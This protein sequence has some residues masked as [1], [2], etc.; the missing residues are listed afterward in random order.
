LT[1]S[2]VPDQTLLTAAGQRL[3]ARPRLRFL[4]GGAGSGK[5]AVARELAARSDVTVVDM[6]ARIY[7]T[8]ADCWQRGRHPVASAWL[9]S[10]DPLAMQLAMAPEAFLEFQ[11]ALAVE[12]LDLLADEL[13][14]E[15][16]AAGW[17]VVDGGFGSIGVLTEAVP[18]AWVACLAAADLDSTALW[19][20]DPDRRAFLDMVASVEA[21]DDPVQRFLALDAAMT[22][23]FVEDA[24]AC[25]VALV[26]HPTGEPVAVTA[27]RAAIQLGLDPR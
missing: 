12:V 10:A 9:A 20:G 13:A 4:A 23:A 14:S 22:A 16:P 21:V 1:R 19:M 26:A 11:D 17:L 15:P 5:S 24:R 25:G 8:W 2:Y 6:D 7:G 18:P 3:R 27:G